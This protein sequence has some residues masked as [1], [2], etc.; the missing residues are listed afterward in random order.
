[1]IRRSVLVV[2]AVVAVVLGCVVAST[3]AGSSQFRGSNGKLAFVSQRGSTDW[4]IWTSN[5]DG[6][7][8]T[9]LTNDN[10]YS[11]Y[12]SW[13]PD[14]MKLAYNSSGVGPNQI[15][16][17]NADGT[18]QTNISGNASENIFPSWSPDGTLPFP[19]PS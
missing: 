16:V 8:M 15:Y 19:I 10:N 18:N 5:A 2:L 4:Q 7:E 11:D 14:G 17:M 3:P 13:S 9:R 6:S 1:M 12:P